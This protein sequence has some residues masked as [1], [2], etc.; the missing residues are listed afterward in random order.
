MNTK[1]IKEKTDRTPFEKFTDLTKRLFTVPKK[2]L[3]EKLG[4][5]KVRQQKK[6]A[7]S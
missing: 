3:D 6:R 4:E 1:E 5:F 2:E 7:V